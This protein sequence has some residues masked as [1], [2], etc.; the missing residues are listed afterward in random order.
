MNQGSW[1]TT[2]QGLYFLIIVKLVDK[3][4]PAGHVVDQQKFQLKLP[5]SQVQ[6]AWILEE[7]NKNSR[8]KHP[9]VYSPGFKG[10]NPCWKVGR[11]ASGFPDYLMIDWY[12]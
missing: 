7:F 12:V 5:Y 4:F 6:I 2:T 9:Y 8:F 1:I 10:E 11:G 3:D